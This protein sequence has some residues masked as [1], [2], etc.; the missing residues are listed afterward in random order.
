MASANR[1]LL[2]SAKVR[3]S[4]LTTNINGIRARNQIIPNLLLRNNNNGKS[5]TILLSI[6]CNSSSDRFFSASAKESSNND[7]N[8]NKDKGETLEE[9]I[10]RLNSEAKNNDS[11]KSESE[12]NSS[13]DAIN[14]ISYKA[15]QF[16]LNFKDGLS[17]TWDELLKS[18][19]AKG[20]HNRVKESTRKKKEVYKGPAELIVID[21]NENL[22]AWEKMQRRLAD[23]PII[24][25]I[26]GASHELYEKS[27][28]K[29]VKHKLDDIKQDAEEVWETSQNPWVYRMSSVYDTFT[30]ETEFATA[31]RILR[32][33]DPSFSM[34]Q[35]LNDAVEQTLP[36]LMKNILEGNIESLEPWLGESVYQRLRAEAQ[37]RRKEGLVLDTNILGLFNAEILAAEIDKSN[38]A[39]DK[40]PVLL[41]HYM[42]Q[43][44]NCVRDSKGKVVEGKEDE[45]KANS[46]LVAFQ[47]EMDEEDFNMT[48]KIVDFRFNG[49]IAW[50]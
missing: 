6:S 36:D 26:L 47:R 10:K 27:G 19:E 21:E 3:N 8:K 28:A 40:E 2:N 29:K 31:T 46:Y 20:I 14:D 18:G 48:W 15:K 37:A 33:L 38:E 4:I 49:A 34:E 22:G 24:Q 12:S 43:Q 7:A 44:I 13:N 17:E 35:F 30:A 50:I 9:T 1:F 23:A 25:S 16:L 42:C 45:I 39:G 32:K 5:I 11:S 41:V